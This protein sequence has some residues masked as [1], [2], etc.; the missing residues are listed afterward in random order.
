MTLMLYTTVAIW[1][2]ALMQGVVEEK[3]N[4]IVEVMVASV[5]T[6]T[7]F[8]GKL[9]GVGAVG[10]TQ[11]VIWAACLVLGGVF[12]APALLGRGLTLE[13]PPSHVVALI[14]FFLLGYFLYAALYAAIGAS[15]NTPQEAQGLVF[16]AFAPLI[17]AFVFC[18]AVLSNPEGSLS[19]VLSFIPPFTPILMFARIVSQAPPY[20][21][22]ALSIVLTL[23]TVALVSWTASRI[24]RVGILMYGKRP[25][26]PEILKWVRSS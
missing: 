8:A 3:A 14:V 25:T 9:L 23:V 1:G 18:P 5:P 21:E 16:L 26:L 24:Y 15:V 2:Q 17:L 22:V 20:W 13:V 7:L 4:R 6:S 19:T 10:L 12:S 11:F